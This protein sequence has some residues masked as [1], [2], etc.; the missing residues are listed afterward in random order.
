LL[1]PNDFSILSK[2][3]DRI[4]QDP[5]THHIKPLAIANIISCTVPYRRSR[6]LTRQPKRPWRSQQLAG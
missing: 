3:N 4:C 6:S 2:Q 1:C 5:Q